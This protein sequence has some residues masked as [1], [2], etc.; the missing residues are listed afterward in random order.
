MK[1]FGESESAKSHAAI[2]DGGGLAHS[3][4]WWSVAFSRTQTALVI[5]QTDARRNPTP[6]I[7]TLQR[8]AARRSE[9]STSIGIG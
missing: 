6:D 2:P 3:A 8:K 4:T 7:R 9:I 1:M 5:P